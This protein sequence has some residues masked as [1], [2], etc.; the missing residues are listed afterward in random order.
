MPSEQTVAAKGS[1]SEATAACTG[2][3]A[4]D[5]CMRYPRTERTE[6]PEQQRQLHGGLMFRVCHCCTSL[7]SGTLLRGT[8]FAVPASAAPTRK[9][10]LIQ[11]TGVHCAT[12]EQ[13]A[14]VTEILLCNHELPLGHKVKV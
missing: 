12:F 2:N 11:M 14:A 3:Y 8:P 10:V 6:Y 5:R 7:C 9:L 4:T 13:D 1:T